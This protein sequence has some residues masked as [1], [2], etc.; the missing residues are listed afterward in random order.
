MDRVRIRVRVRVGVRTGRKEHMDE[1][2][3][4]KTTLTYGSGKDKGGRGGR[5][6]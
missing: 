3:L 1:N 2:D 5:E 4:E 6:R